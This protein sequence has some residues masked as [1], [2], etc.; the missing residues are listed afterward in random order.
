MI[1]ENSMVNRN[2]S[3]N[4]EKDELFRELLE[5]KEDIS[6]W[7]MK[8]VNYTLEKLSRVRENKLRLTKERL[9]L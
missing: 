2:I 7:P 3:S 4:R 5:S 8:L 9:V 1:E 6:L